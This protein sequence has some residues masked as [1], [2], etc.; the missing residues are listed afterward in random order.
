MN[1]SFDDESA[2]KTLIHIQQSA[3]IEEHRPLAAYE[4]LAGGVSHDLHA[5]A[6]T[7][8]TTLRSSI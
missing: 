7:N 8:F 5:P 6:V 4:S 3:P 1:G 2:G